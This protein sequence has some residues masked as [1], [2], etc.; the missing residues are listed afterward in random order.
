[1]DMTATVDSSP[2]FRHF[3]NI[4]KENDMNL[5]IIALM[6]LLATNAALADP[7]LP[8]AQDSN[9]R[10]LDQDI[11][12]DKGDLKRNEWDAAHDQRD[13]NRDR[14]IVG[15]DR[16]REDRDLTNGDAKGAAYWGKQLKDEKANIAHD[17]GDLA[18]SHRDIASDKSRI[19]AAEHSLHHSGSKR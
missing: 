4:L 16:R 17:K 13:I 2:Y 8:P 14:G 12:E 1:V 6:G 9:A 11:R 15:A 3:P 10:Q 19:R 18:H 5:R 7:V